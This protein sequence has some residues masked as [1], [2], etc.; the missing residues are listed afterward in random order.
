[1]MERQK[2]RGDERDGNTYTG[3]QREATQD[4]GLGA[5]LKEGGNLP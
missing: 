5:G 4:I 2:Q 3:K 1:M